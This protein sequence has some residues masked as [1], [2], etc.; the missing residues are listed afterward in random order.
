MT[1]EGKIRQAQL[2]D[3]AEMQ[4]IR[5]A[6]AAGMDARQACSRVLGNGPFNLS[7]DVAEGIERRGAACE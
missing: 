5:E 7:N 2:K 4:T 6:A 1:I 3:V